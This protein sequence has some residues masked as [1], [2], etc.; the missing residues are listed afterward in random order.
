MALKE[1]DYTENIENP[2]TEKV[3]KELTKTNNEIK[4]FLDKGRCFK[5]GLTNIVLENAKRIENGEERNIIP[6]IFCI[7]VIDDGKRKARDRITAQKV[8]SKE[9]SDDRWLGWDYNR[10]FTNKELRRAYKL[11]H[12]SNEKICYAARKTI[13][14]VSLVAQDKNSPKKYHLMSQELPWYKS[15]KAAEEYSKAYQQRIKESKKNGST[16]R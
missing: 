6:L 13:K 3:F 14:L 10:L 4:K 5:N 1:D 8:F 15:K 11:C 12:H 7:D 2:K 16:R 9:E